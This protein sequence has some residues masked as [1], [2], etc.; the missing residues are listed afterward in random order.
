MKRSSVEFCKNKINYA[1]VEF[2][3]RNFLI[4]ASKMQSWENWIYLN[5]GRVRFAENT[6]EIRSTAC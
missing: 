1:H 3:S 2:L 4:Q 5:S 6:A